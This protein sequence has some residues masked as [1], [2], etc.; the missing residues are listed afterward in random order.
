[1]CKGYEVRKREDMGAW[2]EGTYYGLHVSF[3]FV[4]ATIGPVCA[5]TYKVGLYS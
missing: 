3:I 5:L 2:G 4:P 1:M